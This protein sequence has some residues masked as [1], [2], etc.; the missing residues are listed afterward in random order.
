MIDALY[1]G[2]Y[3]VHG[4][5]DPQ[6]LGQAVNLNIFILHI[7]MF[8]VVRKLRFHKIE[9][10]ARGHMTGLIDKLGQS[11]EPRP[12]FIQ[13]LEWLYSNLETEDWEIRRLVC[14]WLAQGLQKFVPLMRDNIITASQRIAL[15]KADMQEK[16]REV[17]GFNVPGF[18][19]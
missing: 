4:L 15:F 1:L 17:P 3:R 6:G 11:T 8:R 19:I 10:E 2:S 13:A 14:H 12:E 5:F 18:T 7:D 16:L 9:E